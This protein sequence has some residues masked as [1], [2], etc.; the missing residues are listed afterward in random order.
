VRKPG[1]DTLRVAKT[2]RLLIAL[3][4]L[5]VLTML[6]LL[7]LLL[8]SGKVFIPQPYLSLVVILIMICMLTAG[9]DI[10]NA[11]P[12]AQM[13]QKNT[14]LHEALEAVEQLN[15]KLRAQRH[16]FL[17]HLQVV[18]S[19]IEMDSFSEAQSLKWQRL[20]LM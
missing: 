6:L 11:A 4:L 7:G 15:G 10:L 5:Q 16:D 2:V 19:L 8:F 3:D 9:A 18:Y 14:S 12:V 17:N 13:G 1:R 20:I